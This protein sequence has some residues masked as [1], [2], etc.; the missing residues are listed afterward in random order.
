MSS[1]VWCWPLWTRGWSQ[2]RSSFSIVS[3]R[4]ISSGR[5]PT[6]V[7]TRSMVQG[8]FGEMGDALAKATHNRHQLGPSGGSVAGGGA[9]AGGI[10]RAVD[11]KPLVG[12]NLDLVAIRSEEHTSELQS[13]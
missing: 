8:L 1:K 6:I 10:E 12:H 3:D 7:I 11:D 2:N 4:R 9:E 13:L 5:V